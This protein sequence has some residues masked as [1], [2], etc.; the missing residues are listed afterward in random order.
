MQTC[1]GLP[2]LIP[3]LLA[4]ARKGKIKAISELEPELYFDVVIDLLT[5]IF[6]QR[7]LYVLI[8]IFLQYPVWGGDGGREQRGEGWWNQA[9]IFLVRSYKG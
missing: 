2:N 6:Q 1:V 3:S 7:S 8:N 9:L 4:G 5:I